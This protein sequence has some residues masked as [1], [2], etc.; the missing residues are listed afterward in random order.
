[1]KESDTLPLLIRFAEFK[2][3]TRAGELRN[4]D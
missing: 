3:D 4:G 1:M 2:L